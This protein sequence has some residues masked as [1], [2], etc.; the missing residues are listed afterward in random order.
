M[1]VHFPDQAIAT[2][3]LTAVPMKGSVGK[4][5]SGTFPVRLTWF[6]VSEGSH[7]P[8]SSHVVFFK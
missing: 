8:T 7:S 1:C 3:Q 4:G 6:F 2:T 5:H